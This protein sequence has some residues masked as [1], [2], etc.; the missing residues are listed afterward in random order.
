MRNAECREKSA[1]NTPRSRRFAPPFRNTS[2]H[3]VPMTCCNMWRFLRQPRPNHIV[4]SFAIS[5]SQTLAYALLLLV[6][7]LSGQARPGKQNSW[8]CCITLSLF[9]NQRHF[10]EQDPNWTRNGYLLPLQ[11]SHGRCHAIMDEDRSRQ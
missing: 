4:S 5:L 2:R 1:Q 7:V 6:T 3:A 10:E 11:S 9:A 8:A